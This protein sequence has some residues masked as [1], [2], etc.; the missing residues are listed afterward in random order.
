MINFIVLLPLVWA[1]LFQVQVH[2]A[3]GNYD[4]DTFMVINIVTEECQIASVEFG[5]SFGQGSYQVYH[6][7]CIDG[8]ATLLV[9]FYAPIEIKQLHIMVMYPNGALQHKY[10]DWAGSFGMPP[11][12]VR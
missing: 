1:S 6:Q 10:V 7:E 11:E 12:V 8:R 3:P 2:P 4:L 5:P 9:S